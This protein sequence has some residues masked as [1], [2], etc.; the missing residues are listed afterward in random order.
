M[1]RARVASGSATVR[2]LHHVQGHDHERMGW[3]TR[4][5]SISDLLPAQ[6]IPIFGDGNGN[7]FGVDFS[8]GEASPA[9]YFFDHEEGFET[10]RYAAGS[11]IS[12]F[13]LLLGEDEAAWREQRP[14]GW[15]LRIDPDI[16]R[17]TRV[18][19]IWRVK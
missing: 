15:E 5:S 1:S 8:S 4:N 19:P 6:A 18:P 7:L 9:V 16:D 17:C 12:M 10:P 14:S 2:Q 3:R 11:S 13:L